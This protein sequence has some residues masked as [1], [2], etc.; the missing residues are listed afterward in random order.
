MVVIGCYVVMVVIEAVIRGRDG[1][2]VAVRL[3]F[4]L[5]EHLSL[6]LQLKWC[7]M[8]LHVTTYEMKKTQKRVEIIIRIIER[9]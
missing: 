4:R 8:H 3:S 9:N 6:G 7:V 2:V 1:I 5:E